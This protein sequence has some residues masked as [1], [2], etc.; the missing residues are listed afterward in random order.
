[1]KSWQE[2]S[3][4]LGRR[5]SPADKSLKRPARRPGAEEKQFCPGITFT[6][7]PLRIEL[8][9]IFQDFIH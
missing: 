5:V 4:G 6:A 7:I 9:R 3:I 8:I 2:R 1:R